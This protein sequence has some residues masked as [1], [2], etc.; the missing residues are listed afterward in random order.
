MVDAS[1]ALPD[2]RVFKDAHEFKQLLLEDRD[3][4]AKAFIEHL[5]IYALRRRLT[6]DDQGD[7]LSIQEVAKKSAYQIQDVVRA[8]ARSDLMRKR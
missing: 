1:G 7:L 8:V 3:V 5:C 6:V 4:I 2:G